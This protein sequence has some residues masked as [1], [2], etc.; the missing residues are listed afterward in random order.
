MYIFKNYPAPLGSGDMIFGDLM[1][2]KLD[3]LPKNVF[4]F[5][6]LA[7]KALKKLGYAQPD[8][9]SGEN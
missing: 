4:I 1:G 8:R 3:F 7:N 6:N 2:K 9:T 5:P